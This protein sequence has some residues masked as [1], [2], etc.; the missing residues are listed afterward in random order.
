MTRLLFIAAGPDLVASLGEQFDS[1]GG[2]TLHVLDTTGI[3]EIPREPHPEASA[4][5]DADFC[6][7]PAVAG[8]L[9]ATG[10]AG[11]I[12]V[13]G[14]ACD[15]ADAALTR[16]FRFATLVSILDALAK[17]SLQGNN[18]GA[19]LTEKETAILERLERAR[20]GVIS[21]EALL[22]EVWGYGPNVVTRTLETHIHRLRRKIEQDP[23]RPRRL[24]TDGGGYRLAKSVG[25]K[26]ETS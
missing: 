10:F 16:P 9:R 20:G 18:F 3:A 6:D 2:F 11:A 19:R 5:L 24:L 1:L 17:S 25:Q 15:D 14:A 7:A 23:R 13:V 12:V 22:E 21:K 8:R 26:P 4:L